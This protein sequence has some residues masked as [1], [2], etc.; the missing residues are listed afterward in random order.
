MFDYNEF[1]TNYEKADSCEKSKLMEQ[2]KVNLYFNYNVFFQADRDSASDFLCYFF[3]VL[4]EFIKRYDKT[5][6]NFFSYLFIIIRSEF[7]NFKK[8]LE[9]VAHFMK[10]IENDTECKKSVAFA[11]AGY[12]YSASDK[13][14]MFYLAESQVDYKCEN[15]AKLNKAIA[16]SYNSSHIFTRKQKIIERILLCRYAKKLGE[17]K[18]LGLCELFNID[19]SE[20]L[21]KLAVIEEKTDHYKKKLNRF[22]G[23]VS[24]FYYQMRGCDKVLQKLDTSN[25]Y[26]EKYLKRQKSYKK[27]W[28]L[29]NA[30]LR[31]AD[32]LPSY[33]LICQVLDLHHTTALRYIKKFNLAVKEICGEEFEKDAS[34]TNMKLASHF[35]AGQS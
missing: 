9:D 19:K 26:Y 15:V 31:K 30:R 17:N 28:E 8:P 32:Y 2:L 35:N 12:R 13:K 4:D 25:M 18:V 33:R 14:S 29:N 34:P 5:R 22:E 21:E 3:G 20:I 10:I 24:K 1:Y 6:G 27:S 23:R 7:K 11:N 16:R